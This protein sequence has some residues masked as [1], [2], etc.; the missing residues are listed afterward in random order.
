M[1]Q[2]HAQG[3]VTHYK[4]GEGKTALRLKRNCSSDWDEKI[5]KR[6]FLWNDVRSDSDRTFWCPR[7]SQ[8]G[9]AI[10]KSTNAFIYLVLFIHSKKDSKSVGFH[11]SQVILHSNCKFEQDC[12][13]IQSLRTLQFHL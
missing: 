1:E 3:R 7:V 5:P 2:W 12:Q 13:I 4:G 11:L 9:Y 10:T 8:G 6:D